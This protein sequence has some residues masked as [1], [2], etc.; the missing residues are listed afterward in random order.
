M[1][2]GLSD[3]NV[4]FYG[5]DSLKSGQGDE[6]DVDPLILESPT[7]FNIVKGLFVHASLPAKILMGVGLA[8]LAAAAITLYVV[9]PHLSIPVTLIVGLALKGGVIGGAT[10]FV[11]PLVVRLLSGY[12][13]DHIEPD[14]PSIRPST[15]SD[16]S[17]TENQPEVANAQ[18][19]GE[20]DNGDRS[21]SGESSENDDDPRL[22]GSD[23][24]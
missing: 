2:P 14:P 5:G 7:F 11:A 9:L 6:P 18:A 20:V 23:S 17:R 19:G 16:I 22:I 1:V 21:D 8:V 4:S 15:F 3:S 13:S 10:A 24:L 12:C